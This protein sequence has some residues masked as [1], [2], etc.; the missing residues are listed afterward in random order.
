MEKYQ[1]GLDGQVLDM[2]SWRFLKEDFGKLKTYNDKLLWWDKMVLS[3][4]FGVEYQ[5]L[6]PLS[7]RHYEQD[8]TM[9][10]VSN[11]LGLPEINSST[12]EYSIPDYLSIIP[13]LHTNAAI[14]WEW[15]ISKHKDVSINYFE[16]YYEKKIS[17]IN[18]NNLNEG[19][20]KLKE[21]LSEMEDYNQMNFYFLQGVDY[22]IFNETENLSL[23]TKMGYI[24]NYSLVIDNILKGFRFK[25]K[26]T[27]LN[28]LLTKTH[29]F[30]HKEPDDYK[31]SGK[32]TK[33]QA[34]YV[35]EYLFRELKLDDQVTK[36]QK[37]KFISF[38]TGLNEEKIRQTLSETV[39][40]NY[41]KDLK[42]IRSYF[43]DLK[44]D[45]I[46]QK[47]TDDISNKIR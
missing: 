34:K 1:I 9:Y 46:S 13:K 44:L 30:S 16:S 23:P 32:I 42:L 37:S 45:T 17:R 19:I 4:L 28:N 39:N 10:E 36:V 11:E 24:Q 20:R 43:E 31:L 26:E 8:I 2:K 21:E 22:A 38:V 5:L 14:F 35:F 33:Q 27:A 6:A 12:F 25:L 7:S 29:L 40:D 3:Q 47:I 41:D 18:P 15:L